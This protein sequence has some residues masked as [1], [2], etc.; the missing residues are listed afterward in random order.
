MFF[1]VRI[2][3]AGSQHVRNITPR[4]NGSGN[5]TPTQ[6]RRPR[7]C[8]PPFDHLASDPPRNCRK[9]WMITALPHSSSVLL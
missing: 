5:L 3:H 8:S 2:N 7:F 9:A 6:L 4:E 1:P